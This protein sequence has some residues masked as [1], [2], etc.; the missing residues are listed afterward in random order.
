MED[1]VKTDADMDAKGDVGIVDYNS[2]EAA[3]ETHAESSAESELNA[4]K[5]SATTQS[6]SKSAETS[7]TDWCGMVPALSM[8]VISFAI[9]MLDVTKSSMA[10]GQYDA[11]MKMWHISA[12]TSVVCGLIFLI[13]RYKKGIFVKVHSEKPETP[14][15][16]AVD[17]DTSA[18]CIEDAADIIDNADVKVS[19]FKAAYGKLKA[20]YLSWYHGLDKAGK[21]QFGFVVCMILATIENGFVRSALIGVPYRSLGV[22]HFIALV[23][24]YT[25]C[26]AHICRASS[27]Y[28]VLNLFLMLSDVLA[29]GM[30]YDNHFLSFPAFRDGRTNSTIFFNSNHYAYFLTMAVLIAVGY[31]LY[32]EKDFAIFGAVSMLLNLAALCVN[33]ATGGLLAVAVVIVLACVTGIRRGEDKAARAK[34]LMMIFIAGTAAVFVI[35]PNIRADAVRLAGDFVSVVSGKDDGQAG[36]GRWTLWVLTVEYIRENPLLGWGCEGIADMLRGATGLGSPHFEILTYAAFFGIPAAV[37]YTVWVIKILV[38]SWK[39]GTDDVSRMTACLA[40]TGYF[41]SSMFGIP[42]FYTLPFFF[43]FLGMGDDVC[44]GCNKPEIRVKEV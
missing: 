33:R 27:R 34:I 40:A 18:D 10:S 36:S 28:L 7:V 15:V 41:I 9:L 31:Y 5:T 13:D 32:A 43:I 17:I 38:R 16:S 19:G 22:L 30:F 6:A 1:L 35:S 42:I 25:I 24:V 12:V 26:S 2:V 20:G 4:D 14:I 11:Y 44:S 3:N 37:I 39:R 23:V 29:I 21:L 8:L